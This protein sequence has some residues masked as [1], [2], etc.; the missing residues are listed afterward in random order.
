MMRRMAQIREAAT[1]R[2]DAPPAVS[3][4]MRAVL[5]A[6]HPALPLTMIDSAVAALHEAG[7]PGPPRHQAVRRFARRLGFRLANEGEEAP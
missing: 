2:G 3:D 4:D 5:L 6:R 1:A 7:R